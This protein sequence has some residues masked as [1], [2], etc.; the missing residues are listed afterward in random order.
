MED[1]KR[2]QEREG[3]SQRDSKCRQVHLKERLVVS[4]QEAYF[5]SQSFAF[6]VV[7]CPRTVG[8]KRDAKSR[9]SEIQAR[10]GSLPVLILLMKKYP[11]AILLKI[12]GRISSVSEAR[13]GVSERTPASLPWDSN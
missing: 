2:E 3:R 10:P 13:K 6:D 1:I 12:T 5:I 4:Y 9:C 8:F 7:S 11:G